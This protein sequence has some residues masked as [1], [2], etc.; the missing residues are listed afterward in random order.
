L[1]LHR[2][3]I[4]TGAEQPGKIKL[5]DSRGRVKELPNFGTSGR[6]KYIRGLF[7]TKP[8]KMYSGLGEA[9]TCR[10]WL[11]IRG[12]GKEDYSDTIDVVRRGRWNNGFS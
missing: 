10:D 5:R 11:S 4:L 6:I 12:G 9:Q 7:L 8:K 3:G 1:K 2:R